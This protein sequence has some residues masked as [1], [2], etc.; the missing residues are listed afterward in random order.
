[1][2]SMNRLQRFQAEEWIV[3]HAEVAHSRA[4]PNCS[5]VKDGAF[6]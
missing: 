6:K 2:G 4:V 3:I 5:L 1:M